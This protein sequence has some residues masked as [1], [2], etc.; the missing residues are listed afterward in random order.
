MVRSIKADSIHF[1]L[2]GIAI[3]GLLIWGAYA[4]L[5]LQT[6]PNDQGSVI[7]AV[8]SGENGWA[9]NFLGKG[10]M[11]RPDSEAQF[12]M[13]FQTNI[14]ANVGA[15]SFLLPDREGFGYGP[16]LWKS[17]TLTDLSYEVRYAVFTFSF[18]S[19]SGCFYSIGNYG[20]A[21]LSGPQGNISQFM[22]ANRYAGLESPGQVDT[23]IIKIETAGN[24]TLH[25]LNNAF[26][27]PANVTGMVAMGPS[28]VV[29]S[30]SWPYLYSGLA[31]I[32]IAAAFSIVTG[33]VSWRKPRHAP[34]TS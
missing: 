24:Y 31:T 19:K 23:V 6:S 1:A 20:N 9:S 21:W 15:S 10:T 18:C 7:N 30:H 17:P 27:P 12:I 8:L 14:P 29:F 2:S 28:S 16:I 34:V 4:V 32:V 26:V 33:F 13:Q 3:L 25:Y 22:N 11:I 5:F